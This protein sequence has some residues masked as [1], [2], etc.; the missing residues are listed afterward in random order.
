MEG[1][2]TSLLENGVK[3]FEFVIAPIGFGENEEQAFHATEKL[4]LH[5]R[6]DLVIG[7]IDHKLARL[8][9]PLFLATGKIFIVINPG[10]NHPGNW[11]APRTTVFVTLLNSFLCSL[12]GSLAVQEKNNRAALAAS[13]YDGGYLHCASLVEGFIRAGGEMKYNFISSQR[14]EDMD[15][16][17]LLTAISDGELNA[18]LALFS[19]RESVL[20][21]RAFSK[22]APR[23][24]LYASPMMFEEQYQA[25]RNSAPLHGFIPWHRSLSTETNLKFSARVTEESGREANIFSLL[26]W[27]TGLLL[28]ELSQLRSLQGE[29]A[30]NSLKE[31]KFNSPR[32]AAYL[33][34]ESHY[35][36]SD[37]YRAL[38]ENG[39]ISIEHFG[40][41]SNEWKLFREV[42]GD[43]RASG[44][45]NTYLCY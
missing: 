4:L 19:G 13:Y 17:P 11:I 33:D 20:F 32:G 3:D 30:I 27:E 25:G 31:K 45:N 16:S 43:T 28:S 44:W 8:L 10:A 1:I 9:D 36:V 6:C 14:P 21:T 39:E 15:V 22:S 41:T 5:E 35:L 24:K 37:V 2:R 29:A 7:F 42:S 34:E 40:E 26:G 18:C 12:T 23:A 38:F